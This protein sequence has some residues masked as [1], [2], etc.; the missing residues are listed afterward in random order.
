MEN[1]ILKTLPAE[2]RH[3]IY[4]HVFEGAEVVVSIHE[5]KHGTEQRPQAAFSCSDHASL[6]KTC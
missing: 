3:E 1:S 2:L 5:S 4:S 6:V